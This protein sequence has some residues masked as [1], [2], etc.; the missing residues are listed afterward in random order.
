MSEPRYETRSFQIYHGLSQ[1]Q[2]ALTLFGWEVINQQ[3]INYDSITTTSGKSHAGIFFKDRATH[4]MS[5]STK[6]LYYTE[7]TAK[8]RI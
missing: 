3:K 7:I 4:D 6:H 5:S 8:R 2:Q 1:Y